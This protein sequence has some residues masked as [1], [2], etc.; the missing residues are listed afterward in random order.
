MWNQLYLVSMLLFQVSKCVNDKLFT[1]SMNGW[2]NTEHLSFARREGLYKLQHLMVRLQVGWWIHFHNS[3]GYEEYVFYF[4]VT[5][6]W[7]TK[8]SMFLFA[9]EAREYC[10]SMVNI[11]QLLVQKDHE[12]RLSVWNLIHSFSLCHS[13]ICL[14]GEAW[15]SCQWCRADPSHLGPPRF[16]RPITCNENF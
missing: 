16:N 8:C 10:L 12:Y 15:I 9:H 3:S 14:R 6:T 7:W 13:A 4:A 5:S 1:T 11:T 2:L